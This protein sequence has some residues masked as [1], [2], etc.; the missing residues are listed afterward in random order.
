MTGSR[1]LFEAIAP[2]FAGSARADVFLS[3]A[4]RRLS[5]RTF[6][7]LYPEAVAYLAAHLLTMS[8]EDGGAEAASAGPVV[9]RGAGSLSVSYGAVG[10]LVDVSDS[11]L[12]QTRYG[13]EYLAILR[14]RSATAP[15]VL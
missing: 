14:S 5:P 3:M 4:A 8:P 15:G 12:A 9:S 2:E 1:E 11:T 7:R 13:R 10:G 6:G